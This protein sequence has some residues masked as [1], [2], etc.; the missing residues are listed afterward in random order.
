MFKSQQANSYALYFLA[1]SQDLTF[2]QIEIK[3]LL[4]RLALKLE[5]GYLFLDRVNDFVLY[6]IQSW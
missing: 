6:L 3:L 2:H 5:T 4:G 1:P